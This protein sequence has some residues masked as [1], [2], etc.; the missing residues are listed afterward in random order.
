M[1]MVRVYVNGRGVDVDATA[2]AIDAVRAFDPATAEQVVL[3][4][5]ALADSRG[6]AAL[7]TAP[8]YG[9]AIFRVVSGR[10][11]DAVGGQE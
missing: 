3:G 10:S 8:V 2:T 5:R 7:A 1:T 6:I 9:G 11:R 4:T